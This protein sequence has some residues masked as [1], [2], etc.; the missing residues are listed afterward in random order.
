M[1]TAMNTHVHHIGRHRRNVPVRRRLSGLPTHIGLCCAVI[2]C[3]VLIATTVL[4]G[5]PS[6]ARAVADLPVPRPAGLTIVS[7]TSVGD[8]YSWPLDG[9]PLVT[10]RFE[11]PPQPWQAGHRGV[12]LAGAPGTVVRAAGP[13]VVHFAGSLAGRGVVSIQHSSGFRTTYEPIQPIVATGDRVRTGDVIGR[14]TAGH[15]ECPVAACLHWGLRL[16]ATYLDPLSLLGLG[17]VRLLPM[18][19]QDH[20]PA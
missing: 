14:L 5:T 12:D 19:S 6:D 15:R 10:L 13:G 17:R 11:P 7:P 4:V 16:G 8:A 2:G 3:A 18:V 1:L 20:Q 9:T